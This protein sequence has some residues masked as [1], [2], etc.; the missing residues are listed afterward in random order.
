M[1]VKKNIGTEQL[2]PFT[3][4]TLTGPF[5]IERTAGTEILSAFGMYSIA[6]RE[7]ITVM[8]RLESSEVL[9]DGQNKAIPFDLKMFW[10][11]NGTSNEANAKPAKDNKSVFPLNN[12]GL[13][14]ENMKDPPVVL[15]AY[16][17]IR[18]TA[19]VPKTTSL[20]ESTVNL[21]VEY[22]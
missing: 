3:I 12:S 18:G 13:L 9:I 11:N 22:E 10:Q 14:V 4:D 1:D 20:Y 5:H 15:H 19:T 17:F 2:I 6:A 7:N 8:V 21:I 16:I